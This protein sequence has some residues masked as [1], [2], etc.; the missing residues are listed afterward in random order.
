MKKLKNLCGVL[1]TS[2]L[3]P[4]G[5]NAQDEEVSTLFRGYKRY[6]TDYYVALET[7]FSQLDK[8]LGLHLGG[9]IG[10]IF[11][12]T[13]SISGAGYGLLPTAK[14][15]FECPIQGHETEKSNNYWSGGYGG[16]FFEYINSPNRLLHFTANTFIGCGRVTYKNLNN[17]FGNQNE[18]FSKKRDFEHPSSIILILEPGLTAELNMTKFFKMSIGISYRYAPNF[19]LMYEEKLVPNTFFNGYSINLV[20]KFG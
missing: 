11:N 18:Y 12:N 8:D 7:K 10:V 2:I 4:L 14:I 5:I 1:L 19:K 15:S 3:L 16:L 17:F 6:D 13:F 9:K 20:F